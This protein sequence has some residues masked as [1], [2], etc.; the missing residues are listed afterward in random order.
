M[1]SNVA[2]AGS[3]GKFGAKASVTLPISEHAI[4]N[5]SE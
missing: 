5:G 3:A 1:P 4:P 2:A